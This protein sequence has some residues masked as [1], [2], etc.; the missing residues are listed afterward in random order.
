M[1]IDPEL[2]ALRGKVA[3]QRQAQHALES[4]RDAWR[5][6]A[7]VTAL[8][9]QLGHYGE[10]RPLDDC[11]T[12]QSMFESKGNGAEFVAPLVDALVK[13]LRAYPLGQI[14]FRHQLSQ[15]LGVLQLAQ[16][17]RAA[18]S[19]LIYDES[20][21]AAAG[22]DASLCFSDGERFEVVLAGAADLQMMEILEDRDVS[23]RIVGT[24]RRVTAG[25]R[26][27]FPGFAWTKRVERVD[28]RLVILRLA[29]SPE[30]PQA[31]REFRLSDG[32]LIHRANG[33]RRESRHEMMMALLGRMRR[34]DAASVFAAMTREGSGHVRW[35]ALR[36]CLALDT[37]MGFA[38]LSRL[39]ND[40]ADPLAPSA[41]ALRAQL[42]EAHPQL[43]QL[44][45]RRCRA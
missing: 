33:D 13:A 45:E 25:D 41:G 28:G 34:H 12:L 44:E 27:R 30:T 9:A 6:S 40:P 7:G 20:S 11:A 42:L 2:R 23:A 15:G 39:A 17:G 21:H 10:G 18:L 37:A 24:P 43:G 31:S 29:R 26:L 22:P 16:S 19:L 4:A 38:A 3:A 5:A 35:Q 36:E 32:A 14:P 1:R 8:L